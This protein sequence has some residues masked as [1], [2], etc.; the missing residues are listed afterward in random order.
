MSKKHLPPPPH[1]PATPPAA[2]QPKHGAALRNPVARPAPPPTLYGPSA[3]IL[4]KTG[5]LQARTAAP[6]PPCRCCPPTRFPAN[7]VQALDD[8]ILANLRAASDR[9]VESIAGVEEVQGLYFKKDGKQVVYV[10]ANPGL[11]GKVEQAREKVSED[12]AFNLNNR[13]PDYRDRDRIIETQKNKEAIESLG[14]LSA[15]IIGGENHSEQNLIK[16]L[17]NKLQIEFEG[18]KKDSIKKVRI[19]GQKSPCSKCWRV[20]TAFATA[21]Q[22]TRDIELGF[23][24]DTEKEGRDNDNKGEI[25][26]LDLSSFKASRSTVIVELANNYEAALTKLKAMSWDDI[27]GKTWRQIQDKLQA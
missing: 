6:P 19:A 8:P 17:M 27:K 5:P 2:A 13:R 1:W 9:L 21:L 14:F 20:L 26:Y 22:N 24:F 10:G 3:P 11:A 4:Q 12:L 18:G 7:V 16:N 15:D 25:T 23:T